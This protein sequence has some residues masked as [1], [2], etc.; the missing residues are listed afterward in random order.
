MTMKVR[1]LGHAGLWVEGAY[2][3][4]MMD[5]WFSP[6]GAFQASWF[7]YPD[8]SHLLEQDWLLKPDAVALSHEHMDHVDPWF[9]RRLDRSVP[10]IIPRYPSRML[11]RKISAAGDRRVVEA[12]PWEEIEVG[13]EL[14]VFFVSEPPMNHDSAIVVRSG[15]R[16]LLNLNDARMFPVQLREIRKRCGGRIDVLAMQG[17]GASW[18]PMC[19]DYPEERHRKISQQKRSAKLSYCSRVMR[20]VD[21]VVALPIAGPPVFLDPE[22]RLHNQEMEGMGVFPDQ[23]QVIEWLASRGKTNTALMLP[24]DV[25]DVE[26]GERIADPQWHDF[27]FGD[28]KAYIEDYAERRRKHVDALLR[29]HPAPTG[30]LWPDFERYF[31]A[32]LEMSEYF[33][34][35]IG[36]RVGFEIAGRGG[37]S[38]AVD[39]RAGKRRVEDSA[40]ECDYVYSFDSKWLPP[41][42][43]GKVPWEDFLLSLR[44]RARRREDRYNDHLLGLLKFADRAA[45]DAVEAFETALDG[46]G[47][48]EIHHEGRTYSVQRKCPHAG[49]DLLDTG[50]LL[51]GGVLRCLAHH[52]DFDLE[53]GECITGNC[54]PLSVIRLK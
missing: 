11:L 19:Y 10:I 41:I 13:P 7:Q 31:S 29:R 44:F 28:R 27:S 20:V 42:L 15:N 49:N 6:E 38:W 45:L 32:L 48:M 43:S 46:G 14:S 16:A 5:P 8:N 30:D 18:Y 9:L 22:L 36:M 26:S 53:T 34:E 52:Y 33:N 37:G 39:F 51:P 47:H 50:E 3:S 24:G 54:A 17:S 35:K 40:G 4:L 21:P 2:G 1:A 23:Q 25:W 12:E